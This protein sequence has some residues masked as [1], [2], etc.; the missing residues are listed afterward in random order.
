MPG[1]VPDVG[2]PA[3]DKAAAHNPA[4]D[5]ETRGAGTLPALL[6]IGTVQEPLPQTVTATIRLV[7]FDGANTDKKFWLG[8]YVEMPFTLK[9]V[10]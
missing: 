7:H 3:V 1:R 2:S 10:K 6:E 8:G 9:T 5:A 4:D